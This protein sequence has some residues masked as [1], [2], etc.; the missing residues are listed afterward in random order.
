MEEQPVHKKLDKR[1][2]KNLILLICILLTFTVMN[3]TMFNVAIPD[4]AEEFNLLPSQVSWVMTG[5][6][7]VFAIGS[8][9]YGKLADLFP[10]KTLLTA[11]I[12]LF[13]SGAALGLFSPNYPTLLA[14][15]VLQA[16]G[17]ASIPALSFI[18]PARFMPG[19]RGKVFGI[20]SSTV[21]FAS[22]LGPIMGGLVGGAFNWRFLFIFSV[23]SLIALPFL[24]RWL[25]EEEKRQT[26][27][28]DILGAVLIAITISAFL[29]FV[30]S[31]NFIALIA[32]AAAGVLSA[33]RMYTYE[34]PFIDPAMLKNVYYAFTILTSFLGTIA[35]FGMIF[36]VPIMARDIYSLSTVEIGLLLFPGAMAAGIIGQFGGK[37]IDRHGS[38]PVVQFA[39][40]F[41]VAGS[42]L[43]STFIGVPPWIISLCILVQYI[44]FP[45]IQSSTA[46]ILT[47]VIPEKRTGVGIGLFN[48]LNFLAGAI[49]SAVFGAILDLQNVTLLLNPVAQNGS[50][51]IYAN[52]FIGLSI[53]AVFTLFIFRTIFKNFAEKHK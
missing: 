24:R 35:M 17:G 16:M 9:M 8:L 40:L 21:A 48:L 4:I 22:G 39:F 11:G 49:A 46:N 32:A 1:E 29:L 47:Q 44:A 15:R 25:P 27:K 3:G 7:L 42:F 50:A 34:D 2:R 13:A 19:E 43:V 51:T 45:L 31:L 14:A 41:V 12:I 52:L 18:I 30:T 23:L 38:Y 53:L 6:I 26:G 5:Y 36:V 33:W 37:L 20:V 10:I 28:V